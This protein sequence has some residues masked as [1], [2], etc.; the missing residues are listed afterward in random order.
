MPYAAVDSKSSQGFARP[1]EYAGF[2]L[3]DPLEKRIGRVEKIF[4]NCSGEPE[5]IGVRISFFGFKSV[6]L[7]VKNVVVDKQRRMLVL[8]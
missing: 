5:H 1:E 3:C 8:R 4:V 6:L 2:W 7:P